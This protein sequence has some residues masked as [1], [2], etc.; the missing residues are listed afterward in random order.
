MSEEIDEDKISVPLSS[1]DS[2]AER[3][4]VLKDALIPAVLEGS[5]LSLPQAVSIS[6]LLP[7]AIEEGMDQIQEMCLNFLSLSVAISGRGRKDFV[8]CIKQIEGYSDLKYSGSL[9]S[10]PL[11]KF[12]KFLKR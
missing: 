7:K 3:Y 2:G 5:V 12:S 4:T 10:D 1:N 11:E 9:N 6:Y 8:E